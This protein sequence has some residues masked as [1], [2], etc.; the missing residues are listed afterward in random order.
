M[1]NNNLIH[2]IYTSVASRALSESDVKQI[3]TASRENNSGWNISGMLLFI[4]NTFFQILEG[5]K[6]EV[7]ALY[8]KI[9]M[10][11]RHERVMKL[12]QEPIKNR[13]FSEWTWDMQ[14]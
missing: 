14:P 7:N 4:D 8:E 11:P 5:D 13:E 1:K 2:L 3:L 12:I 10:D 6:A 9:N